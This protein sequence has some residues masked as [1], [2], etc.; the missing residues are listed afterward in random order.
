MSPCTQVPLSSICRK[1]LQDTVLAQEM[2][3]KYPCER[4]RGTEQSLITVNR[5]AASCELCRR[6]LPDAL[7]SR[8]EP[9]GCG[10]GTPS[11]SACSPYSIRTTVQGYPKDDFSSPPERTIHS[12]LKASEHRRLGSSDFAVH[13]GTSPDPSVTHSFSCV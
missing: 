6:C 1:Y 10:Y 4:S 13:T 3:E 9:L 8:G 2:V 11:E 7:C 12:Q 5:R